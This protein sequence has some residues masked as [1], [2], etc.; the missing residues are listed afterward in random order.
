M[1]LLRL[2]TLLEIDMTLDEL[3][4]ISRRADG[5]RR[6]K[7]RVTNAAK[8]LAERRNADP[9][10]SAA[11]LIATMLQHWRYGTDELARDKFFAALDEFLPDLL[12]IAEM[13]LEAEARA[14]GQQERALRAQLAGFLGEGDEI[15]AREQT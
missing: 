5:L 7:E 8:M 11:D 4:A 10:N 12:R 2:P 6:D 13:R 15:A 1:L 14:L 3:N 9:R